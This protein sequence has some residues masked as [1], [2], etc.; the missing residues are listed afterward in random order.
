M[1]DKDRLGASEWI[2]A[3]ASGFTRGEKAQ[4]VLY[5]G[6][7]VIGS[8]TVDAP[9]GLVARFRIPDATPTGLYALEVTGWQSC[10]VEQGEVTVV[11]APLAP[12]PPS[13]WWVYVVLGVLL[14]GLLSLSITFRSDIARWFGGPSAPES[15]G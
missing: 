7:V 12:N 4:V 14:V 13:V 9:T 15:N 8:Y 10:Y 1:V 11:N 2:I 3:S 6:A 5:P